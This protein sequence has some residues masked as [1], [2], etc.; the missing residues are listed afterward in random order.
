MHSSLTAMIMTYMEKQ[1]KKSS[2]KLRKVSITTKQ[3]YNETIRCIWIFFMPETFVLLKTEVVVLDLKYVPTVLQ[4]LTAKERLKYIRRQDSSTKAFG[5]VNKTQF[6]HIN[7]IIFCDIYIEHLRA[8]QDDNPT[9]S[10]KLTKRKILA[11][12]EARKILEDGSEASLSESE[13][14]MKAFHNK[15]QK[16][17]EL[18]EKRRDTRLTSFLKSVGL[19]FLVDFAYSFFVKTDGK[20]LIDKIEAIDKQDDTPKL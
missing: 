9:Y 5:N 15:L 14:T 10:P 13:S 1:D 16:H 18:L 11:V 3:V 4:C 2:E 12:K 6:K 19:E 17:Q 8:S 20:A 7:Y